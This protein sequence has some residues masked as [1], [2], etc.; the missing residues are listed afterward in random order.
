MSG[1]S[2]RDESKHA[3]AERIREL[4]KVTIENLHAIGRELTAAKE[5]LPHGELEKWVQRT[6]MAAREMANV[7]FST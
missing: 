5:A 6:E 4:A 1:Y 3:A 7:G 2:V